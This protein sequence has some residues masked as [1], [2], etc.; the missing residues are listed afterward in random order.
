MRSSLEREVWGS[1][2]GP[3]KSSTE[4]PTAR[5]RFNISLMG[6]ALPG[7]MTPKCAPSTCYTLLRNATSIMKDLIWFLLYSCYVTLHLSLKI[8]VSFFF[9]LVQQKLALFIRV[10][11]RSLQGKVTQYYCCPGTPDLANINLA[12]NIFILSKG[13]WTEAEAVI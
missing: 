13:F 4:L 6:A 3:V 11:W 1:Y 7:A 5:H 9:F 12:C 10:T 8:T 2:V